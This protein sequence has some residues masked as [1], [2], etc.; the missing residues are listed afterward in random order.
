MIGNN[1][2]GKVA[3]VTGGSR[4]IGLALAGELIVG[5]TD[6]VVSGRSTD[7]LVEAGDRLDRFSTRTGS[8]RYHTVQADVRSTEDAERMLA[9]AVD[10]FGGLDILINNAGIGYFDTVADQ[11]VED[12]KQVI[13]TNLTGVFLACRAA[14]P[15]MRKRGSGWIINISSLAGSHPFATGAAYCASKAGLDAFTTALMQELRY[16][17]IRVSSVAPGSVGTAF[18]GGG[19]HAMEPWKLTSSDVAR[20]VV[21]LLGH[22]ARSLPSRVEIRPSQPQKP[23]P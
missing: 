3:V 5:G 23:T 16:D 8:G 13:D 11:S 6:V 22:D 18:A 14:I 15:H 20:I 9:S 19:R 21:D 12:W 17:N 1:T 10:H 4:G 2:S 7:A